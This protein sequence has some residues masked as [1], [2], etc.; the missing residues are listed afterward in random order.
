MWNSSS[1][2]LVH[3]TPGRVGVEGPILRHARQRR[4]QG[5]SR[6]QCTHD[7]LSGERTEEFKTL[8]LQE[9]TLLTNLPSEFPHKIRKN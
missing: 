2:T 3:I 8:Q 7:K 4:W 1:L 5:Y 6:T 9:M